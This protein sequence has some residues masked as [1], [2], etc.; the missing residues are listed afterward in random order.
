MRKRERSRSGRGGRYSPEE[1][2]ASDGSGLGRIYT[3]N[4]HI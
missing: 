3:S 1:E 4:S 2:G